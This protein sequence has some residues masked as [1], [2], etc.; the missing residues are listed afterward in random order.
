[1][2]VCNIELA[3]SG[4]EVEQQRL[5]RAKRS[6]K[7]TDIVSVMVGDTFCTAKHKKLPRINFERLY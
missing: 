6:L 3:F 1:M 7:L 2:Q 5:N 4:Q